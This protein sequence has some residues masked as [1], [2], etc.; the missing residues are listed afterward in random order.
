[1]SNV[2]CQ[3][4]ATL[5]FAALALFPP[6]ARAQSHEQPQ[7][8]ILIVNGHIIDG[9]GNPWYAAAVAISGDHIAAIGDLHD[10]HTKRTI[11]ATGRIVAPGFID[12]LGQSEWSLLVDNRCL[13]K[14]SQ[15]I[16]TEITGEGSSIA[17]QNDKT[18]AAMKP[19]LDQYHVSV[20][21]TTLDG[22][23]RRL[24]KQGTPLNLGTYVGSAQV[25]KVVIGFDD[26]DPTAEELERMKSLVEQAMKDGALGVSSYL[27]YPPNSYAKT[28]ELIEL[29]KVASQYGGIYATHMRSEGPTEMEALAEAIRIGREA[30][31]PVEVFHLKVAGKSRWGNMTKIVQTIQ[32]ARDSGLDI[33]ADMYPY[34]ASGAALSAYVPPWVSDGGRQKLLERLKD[35]AVRARIK[36]ELA[37]DDWDNIYFEAGGA[38]HVLVMPN[39]ADLKKFDGKTLA[40]VAAEW[41]KSPED[42]LMDLI[43]ADGART[44]AVDFFGSEDDL[45]TAL[46]QSWTSIGL[47]FPEMSLDGPLYSRHFHPRAFGSMPRFLG[48][49]IRDQRLLPIEAAIRKIT[50]F[51]AQREHLERR[52]Q[53]QP[54]FFADITVFDPATI[55]DHATYVQPDQPSMGIDFVVVNGQLEYEGG[56]PTGV[57]AGRVLRGRGYHPSDH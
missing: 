20:D 6:L 18:L 22:Y 37:I 25:R 46:V 28:E 23:F 29:S 40:E 39:S 36:K 41:G 19:S 42:T 34:V 32:E 35:P 10:A 14:L 49:Y 3:A 33:T 53:L 56:K 43:V 9:T 50:S 2:N 54:G 31:L 7:Y 27:I 57:T 44:H 11:D 8:D 12:M 1:M 17:P 38:Q 48:S 47:D 52:G 16:T 5:L 21:W 45:R 15:G 26:R 51:P 30:H 4:L 55:I 24:E 13:S